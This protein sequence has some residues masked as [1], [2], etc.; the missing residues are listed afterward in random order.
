MRLASE[1]MEAAEEED[2]ADDDAGGVV[3]DALVCSNDVAVGG[4]AKFPNDA[5]LMM[6]ASGPTVEPPPTRGVAHISQRCKRAGL[7]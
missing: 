3:E 1:R 2:A 6:C 7:S 5:G 4:V